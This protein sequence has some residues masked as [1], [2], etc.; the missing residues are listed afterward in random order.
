MGMGLWVA[1]GEKGLMLL[2][3]DG[4][5]RV[6]PPGETLCRARDKIWCAGAGRCRCYADRTGEPLWNMALPTG[7]CAMAAMGSQVYALSTD[8]DSVTA[9]SADRGVILCCA[10]AGVYPRDLCAHPGGRLLLTAGGASGKMLLFDADLN[11]LKTY[12]LPGTVCGACF[13]G[14]GMGALCAVERG[15][16]LG[17]RLYAVSFRGNAEEMFSLP[18]MPGFLC[19]LPDGGCVMG[20][21]GEIVRFRANKKAALRQPFSCPLRLR[22]ARDSM[23]LCEAGEGV[24]SLPSRRRVYAGSNALDALPVSHGHREETGMMQSVSYQ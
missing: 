18:L 9:F 12:R 17:A 24:F 4:C 11:K 23:L 13:W 20:C 8:A 7:V 19:G 10:P 2:N 22:A 21:C 3:G 1:D 6:G 16:T 15:E 5:R 14:R